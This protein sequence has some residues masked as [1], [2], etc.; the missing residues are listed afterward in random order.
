MPTRP[1]IYLDANCLIDAAKVEIKGVESIQG[2]PDSRQRGVWVI[3][4]ILRAA[5]AGDLE[6]FTSTISIA[7]CSHIGEKPPEGRV[8][9]LFESVLLSGRCLKLVESD[10]FVC[11]DARDLMWDH[12]I[13]LKGADAIHVASARSA[14]C[15]ELLTVDRGI[16]DNEK[17]I[18]AVIELKVLCPSKT[19]LLPDDYRQAQLLPTK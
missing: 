16:L 7:E 6:V 15:E 3:Q 12:G 19:Q 8:K 17:A 5:F 14:K 9:Q 10:V 13:S 1:R 18:K 4:Q 11:G 2:L